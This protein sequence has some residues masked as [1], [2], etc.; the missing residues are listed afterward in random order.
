VKTSE[1]VKPANLDDFI[2]L[3]LSCVDENIETA[4]FLACVD[5]HQHHHADKP[6]VELIVA[7]EISQTP[8]THISFLVTD[9]IEAVLRLFEKSV[10]GKEAARNLG[11]AWVELDKG[12]LLQPVF[13]PKPWG[14]E[15]WYSGI[16][17]RGVSQVKS[18]EG[19]SPLD[20]VIAAAPQ[21][22][23]G[24]YKIPTLLKILDPLPDE[25]LG[26]L[27]FEMHEEKQ[28]V[29]VVTHINRTAWPDGEGGI[30]FGFNQTLRKTFTS[31][32]AFKQAYLQAVKNYQQVRQQIDGLLDQKRSLPADLVD[33]EKNLRDRM[34]SFIAIKKLK[35]GDVV[36]VPCFTP[37]SL[38]HGVRTVEFQTP[39]Y[40]RKILSFAQKVL[41][42]SHWDTEEA[43]KKITLDTPAET[44]LHVVE[45]TDNLCR[46]DIVHFDGFKVERVTLAKNAQLLSP[47]GQYR[48]LLVV[49]GEVE[50]GLP[51]AT[52]KA[53][54]LPA[55]LE[56]Q[57]KCLSAEAVFLLAEPN[58]R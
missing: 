41:T 13:I 56:L 10:M 31:D 50:A 21:H 55:G 49:S 19:F 33:Q 47:A 20:W 11:V 37:H 38:Q 22:I 24:N 17:S 25:V 53:G 57:I 42:Q 58:D 7:Y 1:I 32:E 43:L 2:R 9:Q 46:E 40:E 48:L 54:L 8:A 30:R 3:Q 14:Q 35:S 4:H 15:I 51:L 16:E 36:K 39:V 28:E 5:H 18:D 26:D 45:K 27:Y 34:E 23:L 29:Y 52:E 12:L 44:T 6:L